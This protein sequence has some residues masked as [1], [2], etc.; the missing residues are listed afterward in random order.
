MEKNRGR[1]DKAALWL[2]LLFAGLGIALIAINDVSN[3]LLAGVHAY[4]VGE[5][6]WARAQKQATISIVKY[7]YT[8]DEQFLDTFHHNIDVIEGN[9]LGRTELTKSA[10]NYDVVEEEFLRGQHRPEDIPKLVW[11]YE[12]LSLYT[13]FK[14]AVN[15]W[16]EGDL[17]I[18]FMAD[19]ANNV[20]SFV[21]RGDLTE[22][23]INHLSDHIF[24]L[25]RQLATVEKNFALSISEAADWLY[26]RVYWINRIAI[27]VILLTGLIFAIVRVE[28][29][30]KWGEKLYHSEKKFRQVLTHSKDV[31]YQLDIK[32]GEYIYITPSVKNLLGYTSE[33]L[34]RGGLSFVLSLTH[35][36]DLKRMKA[37]V[38]QYDSDD[39]EKIVAK[40]SEF[41]FKT[42]D[43]DYKWVSNKRSVL[44]DSNGKPSA[45]I[46]N[47]RDVSDW[48]KGV[49]EL[50][51]SVKEKEMLLS[52]IHHRV[53]NNL[54]IVS[55]L[56]ELQKN[57]SDNGADKGL[58]EIQLR[59]K[60][61]ALVHE[62]L[63]QN[64]TFADVDLAE[65]IEDLVETVYTTFNT[66][67][68]KISLQ[69]NMDSLSVNIKRAVPIGLI[70]NEMLNNCYK[71]AFEGV[72][73]GVI[74]ID[75]K[76]RDNKAKL[77]I[78]DNGIGLPE[79]FE[80]MKKQSLGMTLIEV[81]T[82]QLDGEL[83]YKSDNGTIFTIEFDVDA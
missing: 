25:E 2:V 3:R 68:K 32:T 44:K 62:K 63:Y 1:S 42:K 26:T 76:V 69:K 22:S 30:R 56:I 18:G 72:D 21:E 19:A 58:Q 39:I 29:L 8:E 17:L 40:D 59:I 11:M 14:I 13:P 83:S 38:L 57:S 46:G 23:E 70:C 27:V 33:E 51:S 54:S 31:I 15:H 16:I 78:S 52:E 45:I 66:E 50:S 41:R 6:H 4:T 37:E 28:I 35:P 5:G 34:I 36:E 82:K 71:Y 47:V 80:E 81:F 74:S 65:Y 77:T 79:D 20:E 73:E 60:S 10:P 12:K 67:E 7:L 9:R 24:Y 49:L 61:I 75:L 48:K 64:E 55:S 43:G 53:K